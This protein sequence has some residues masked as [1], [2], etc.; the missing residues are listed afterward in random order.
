[1]QE[2]VRPLVGEN[3]KLFGCRKTVQDLNAPA[4]GGPTRAFQVIR[5]FD[6]NAACDDRCAQRCGLATGIAGGLGDFGERLAIGLR[7]VLSRDSATWS[8]QRRG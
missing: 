3:E 5:R 4:S 6:S 1:M 8:R 7:K 2:L